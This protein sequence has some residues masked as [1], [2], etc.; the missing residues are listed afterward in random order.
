MYPLCHVL[1]FEDLH[2]FMTVFWDSV[3]YPCFLNL[4]GSTGATVEVREVSAQTGRN[5]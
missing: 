1:K 3:V 5:I 2:D 4:P